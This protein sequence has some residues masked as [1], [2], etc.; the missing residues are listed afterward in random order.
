MSIIRL[1]LGPSLL[2]ISFKYG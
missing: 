1:R 2:C